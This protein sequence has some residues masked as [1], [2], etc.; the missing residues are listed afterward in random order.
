MSFPMYRTQNVKLHDIFP[1][2]ATLDACPA[3]ER[4]QVAWALRAARHSGAYRRLKLASPYNLAAM[5][6]DAKARELRNEATLR[7]AQA[8]ETLAMTLREVAL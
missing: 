8:L 7:P 2:Q 5:A 6:L 1:K 4:D 3:W